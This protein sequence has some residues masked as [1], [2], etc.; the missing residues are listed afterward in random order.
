MALI[1][2]RS[3][4]N[5][6]FLLNDFIT[7]AGLDVLFVTE[8]WLQPGDLTPLS[9]LLPHDFAFKNTPRETGRGG[10][11]AFIF[12]TKYLCRTLP[13]NAFHS[14]EL[15]L[16]QFDSPNPLVVALIYHP[17]KPANDF[18]EEFAALLS[19]LFIK[20]DRL[21]IFL[22]LVKSFDLLQWVNGSTHIQGHMLNLVLS[23]N[24]CF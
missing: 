20:Y 7:S 8:T 21:M 13:M 5:K 4:V 12:K 6:T 16:Y 22:N 3:L 19:E 24:L 10:G 14:F 11:V 9:E 23:H 18:I 15:Q 2:A 17:P 1:N